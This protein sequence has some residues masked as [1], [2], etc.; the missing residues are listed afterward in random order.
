MEHVIRWEYIIENR[1]SYFSTLTYVVGAQ[2]N[3]LDETASFKHPKH[4]LKLMYLKLLTML[5]RLL[6]IWKVQ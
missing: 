3:S 2:N 4:L 5:L 6:C 1:F